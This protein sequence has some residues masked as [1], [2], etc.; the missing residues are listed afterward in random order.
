MLRAGI[1]GAGRIAWS[2]DFGASDG[3]RSVSHAA[4]LDRHPETVLK[5]IFDPEA[6]ARTRFF[7]EYRGPGPVALCDTLDEFLAHNL[8]LVTI[9][10][11]SELH[12]GHIDACL[13]ASIP[14]L[15]IEKPVTTDA[16]SFEALTRQLAQCDPAP[17]IVVNY[18]RRFLPQVAEAKACLQSALTT[19]ALR[20]IDATYSR[21]FVVNGVHFLDLVG[22]LF[23]VDAAPEFDWVDRADTDDPSFGLTLAGVPVAV[24]GIPDLGYHALDLRAVTDDGRLALTQGGAELTWEAKQPNPDFPGFFNLSAPSHVLEPA[25]TGKAMLDGTYLS[26]CD[27]VD[28][29]APSR[30]PLSA[31]AFTQTILARLAEMSP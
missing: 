25:I 30:S 6:E 8:D 3:H 1:I 21:S 5:A 7:A 28:D 17:R 18:F 9:A 23:N 2:Y 10:S 12:S 15:W 13:N 29:R 22:H 27:L 26:L 19:G 24:Q 14:R 11:P 4:C 31:S 20:R 16:A